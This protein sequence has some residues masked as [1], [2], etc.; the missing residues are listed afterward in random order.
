MKRHKPLALVAGA[1]LIVLA[2]CGGSADS[3]GSSTDR[4]FQGQEGGTKDAEAQGPVEID[5][6]TDG[7]TVT[8]YT[9]ARSSSR[10]ARPDRRLVGRPATRSSRP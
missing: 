2:A 6:A 9:P 1:S 8:V 7:G 4:E 3:G 10:H 5:G